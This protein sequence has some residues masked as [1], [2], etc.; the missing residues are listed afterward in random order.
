MKTRKRKSK[1]K[2]RVICYVEKRWVEIPHKT[3]MPGR[4][5][6]YWGRFKGS[7]KLRLITREQYE[8]FIG[9]ETLKA[10][11]ERKQGGKRGH[12]EVPGAGHCWPMKCEALAC[13]PTQVAAF[14]E[15]NK[16]HGINV[17]YDRKG[18]AIIPDQ[19]AYRRLMKAEKV[20]QNNCY[21]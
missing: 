6:E 17:E 14:N 3:G 9:T 18:F 21:N 16:N 19:A 12:G 4:G 7:K 15:R 13:H 5:L 8:D 1:S 20:H 2:S 11:L 10:A